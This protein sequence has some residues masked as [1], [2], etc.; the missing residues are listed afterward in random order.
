M[1][2]QEFM[3]KYGEVRVK[4]S[5]YSKFTFYFDATLEDGSKLYISVGGDSDD[6][7]RFDVSA[8]EEIPV[9]GLDPY[10][11]KVV[12]KSGTSIVEFYDY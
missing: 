7:Y 11:G 12:D 9:S 1:T 2:K 10:A 3:E 8:D 5:S 6:I 4:F